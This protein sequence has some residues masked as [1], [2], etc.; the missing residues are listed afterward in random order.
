ML[1]KKG[2]NILAI[3]I[4]LVLPFLVQAEELRK[5]SLNPTESV[6]LALNQAIFSFVADPGKTLEFKLT[7]ENTLQKEEKIAVYFQDFSVEDNN[8][9]QILSEANELS[10]MKDWLKTE[11]ENLLLQPGEKKEMTFVLQIPAVATVGSHYAGIFFQ[12]FPSVDAQNFQ[13]TLVSGRVGA[14]VL[15]N[16]NGEVSGQGNLRN[17]ETPKIAKKE[18][19]FIAEF[20]NTGNVFYVPHG[21]IQVKNLL[22]KKEKT[23]EVPKH[24]VFPGKK[25]AFEV[26]WNPESIFG[27]YRA[28]AFFVDGEKNM[29]K[30]SRVVLGKMFFVWPLLIFILIFL[31]ARFKK[32]N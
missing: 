11:A 2:K 8:Q 20:E 13:K 26:T 18:T 28:Q 7:V 30:D 27:I 1:G 16:V 31:I 23:L 3:F 6:G 15:L 4:F 9:M 17:F 32:V 5:E 14:Y 10:G 25:Y 21:E 29:H 12:A 24:F 22:T 19:K